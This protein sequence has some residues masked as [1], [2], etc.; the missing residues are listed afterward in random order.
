MVLSADCLAGRVVFFG[1]SVSMLFAVSQSGSKGWADLFKR[2]DL[3]AT[4]THSIEALTNRIPAG[5]HRSLF[6]HWLARI[7]P[8]AI[9]PLSGAEEKVYADY[10]DQIAL[11]SV[12]ADYGRTMFRPLVI[13]KEVSMALPSYSRSLCAA[14]GTNFPEY[15]LMMELY[16]DAAEHL[17]PS[18]GRC[19][20]VPG[21][22][23][24]TQTAFPIVTNKGTVT[25]LLCGFEFEERQTG[26]QETGDL[27]LWKQEG[28]NDP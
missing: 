3:G 14:P 8:D 11:I 18:V 1:G 24:Y 20:D 7:R 9:P 21:R 16:T 23:R 13:G 22:A 19:A 27:P 28:D 15:E 5:V 2:P 26:S 6:V 17:W 12:E 10:F 4:L 25:Q